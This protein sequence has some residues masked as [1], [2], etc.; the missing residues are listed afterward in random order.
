MTERV[1]GGPV[2]GS[3]EQC[4]RTPRRTSRV[5]TMEEHWEY[6]QVIASDVGL[7]ADTVVPDRAFMHI[8]VS[9]IH[10]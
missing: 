7:Q 2:A 1:M 5:C 10:A 4:G 3:L 6:M 9:S 8:W